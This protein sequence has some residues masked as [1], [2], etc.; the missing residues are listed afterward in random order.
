RRMVTQFGMSEKIGLMAL[1]ATHNEY[2]DG[3]SYM[4]CAQST[5][6]QADSEVRELLNTCYRKAKA[7]LLENRELLDEI[8]L[9]L[10]QKETITGDEL[11]AY[12]NAE[13]DRLGDHEEVTE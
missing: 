4:D 8:A 1:A 7:L 11:M 9:Y 10:L 5:A 6:A 13:K 3:Q 12:V 2:L